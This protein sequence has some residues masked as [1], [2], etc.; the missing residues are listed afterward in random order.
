MEQTSPYPNPNA[1]PNWLVGLEQT[2][3]SHSIIDYAFPERCVLILTLTLTLTPTLTLTLT[4]VSILLLIEDVSYFW[5]RSSA[6]FPNPNPN[7]NPRCVLLLGEEQ[8]GI[9][10]DFIHLLDECVEIPQLGIVRSLNVHV[11][12]SICIWE[13][14]RQRQFGGS[15]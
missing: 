7:P 3:N 12:A 8:R 13:Y 14:T 15:S 10:A 4:I 2:S 6:G 5:E 9:P 1:N 11:S